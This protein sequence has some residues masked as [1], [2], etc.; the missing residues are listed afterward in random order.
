[1]SQSAQE[2]QPAVSTANDAGRLGPWYQEY[3]AADGNYIT[4]DSDTIKAAQLDELD[5]NEVERK[6]Q[7]LLPATHVA[8]GFCAKCRHLFEHWPDLDTE[9][10]ACEVV[11]YLDTNE[12][13]AATRMGCQFCAFL[14]C[15][16]KKVGLLATF[17]KL[18]ARLHRL[19]IGGS[20]SL[21]IQNWGRGKIRSQLLWLNFPGKVADSCNYPGASASK[22]ESH[23]MSPTSKPNTFLL[24]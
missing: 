14:L 23:V 15:R 13:E 22:F 19:D 8:E 1:M 6:V 5:D 11:R 7:E 4:E 24:W 17:R 10:W 16:L 9:D 20:A 2:E 3:I 18:E 12:I 21:S